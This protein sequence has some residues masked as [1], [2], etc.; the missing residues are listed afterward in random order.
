V[1][2]AIADPAAASYLEH[3]QNDPDPEVRKNARWAIQQILLS[4][5]N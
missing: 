2:I 5:P 3:V 4:N 1:S